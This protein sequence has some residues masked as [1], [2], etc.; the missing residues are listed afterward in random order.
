MKKIIFSLLLLLG[1]VSY[2]AFAENNNSS[3]PQT[4]A[5]KNQILS[6]QK[7]MDL[8]Q[9]LK[10]DPQIK[11]A[12]QDPEISEAIKTG[13]IETLYK[14]KKFMRLVNDSQIRKLKDEITK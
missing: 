5:V 2:N 8:I 14:N 11:E 6:N 3:I 7:A 10:N 9:A 4:D 13:N 12:I 1:T